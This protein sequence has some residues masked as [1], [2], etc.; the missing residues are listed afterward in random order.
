MLFFVLV[1]TGI[2]ATAQR[3][4]AGEPASSRNGYWMPNHDTIRVFLVFAEVV[5]DPGDD[6]GGEPDSRWPRGKMPV[7]ADEYFD[8]AV[9]ANGEFRSR[10]TRFFEQASFGQYIMLGDYYPKLAQIPYAELKGNGDENIYNWLEAQPGDDLITASGLHFTGPDFDR[11]TAGSGYAMKKVKAPDGLVDFILIMWRVNTKITRKDNSG[12]VNMSALNKPIKG[13]N[14]FMDRSRFVSR[15]SAGGGIIQHEYSH[16]LYGGNNFHTGGRGAGNATFMHAMGGF[17]NLSS[18][19]SNSGTW[20]AWDRH[21]MGW[22]SPKKDFYISGTCV[23]TGKEINLDLAYRQ[24]LDCP[25]ME[26]YLDDFIDSGDALRIELPYVQTDNPDAKRQYLWIEN[27]QI[28]P[29]NEDHSTRMSRGV[30]AYV[31]VGKDDTASFDGPGLYTAPLNAFGHFDLDVDAENQAVGIRGNRA[32]A[33]TGLHLSMIPAWNSIEPNVRTNNK[34]DTI[35]TVPLTIF[36]EESVYPKSVKVGIVQMGPSEFVFDTH[37]ALGT[38]HDAFTEGAVI[39]VG[40]NPGPTPVYTWESRGSNSVAPFTEPRRDDNRTIYLNGIRIALLEQKPDGRM[41][42]RLDWEADPL[43]GVQRWCGR[44]VAL[45]NVELAPGAELVL[46]LG[47][48]PQKPVNPIRVRGE[49][50]F[51]DTTT[52]EMRQ[53]ASILGDEGSWLVLRAG[54]RMLLGPGSQ[55]NLG[56]NGRLVLE[57]GS[58][59]EFAEGS[60]FSLG[61]KASIQVKGGV[62]LDHGAVVKLGEGIKIKAKGGQMPDWCKKK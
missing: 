21:R 56:A 26:F 24:P 60:G 36:R 39:E 14:G 18:Y 48:S 12:S 23:S 55:L 22:K 25:G 35:E 58:V 27:H 10:M 37:P 20:N 33:F 32:N 3:P 61:D 49:W 4:A 41:R 34:G 16:S 40:K 47:Y 62:I 2:S 31:Q 57:E 46:D 17:G 38:V 53:G 9:P 42:I 5:G 43:E 15:H 13:M 7:N 11:W 1:L 51:S 44:I 50:V 54:S 28:R 59:L 19:G 30:Y 29:G 8:V 6:M 52:L 45:E